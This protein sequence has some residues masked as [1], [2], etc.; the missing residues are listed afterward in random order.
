MH[1]EA[2]PGEDISDRP[3]PEESV[4]GLIELLE[5]ELPSGRY[6]AREL[7]GR[8]SSVDGVRE[9][10]VA[11]TVDDLEQAVRLY[12]DGLG[13]PVKFDWEAPEGRGVVLGAGRA[14]L[15]LVDRAQAELIDRVEV[16][17]RVA[18]PVRLAFEVPEVAAAGAALADSGAQPLNDVVLTPWGDRNMRLRAPDGMQITLFQLPAEDQAEG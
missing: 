6:K 8:S 15:E 3:P 12:R 11:L 9:L 1:Q 2:F 10:R 16:G 18:G 7:A 5:G 13:L 4:P 17:R 14:T